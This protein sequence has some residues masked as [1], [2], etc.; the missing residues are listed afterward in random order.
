MEIERIVQARLRY[1]EGY[2]PAS[3]EETAKI[4]MD[5]K[6]EMF[7]DL[8][9]AREMTRPELLLDIPGLPHGKD[10]PACGI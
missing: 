9:G 6:F 7:K 8:V 2:L 10:F 3:A 4:M 5:G 1:I